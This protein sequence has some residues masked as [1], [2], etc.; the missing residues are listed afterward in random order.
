[1]SQPDHSK[2]RAKAA[3]FLGCG[4]LVAVAAV[5]LAGYIQW[6]N[7]LPPPEP[8]TVKLPNPN[9][10]DAIQRAA[11]GLTGEM[12]K[13]PESAAREDLER[14]VRADAAALKEVRRALR[15]PFR[16]PAVRPDTAGDALMLTPFR[17]AARAFT[18]EAELRRRE[19]RP[20][21]C[22]QGA[23]DT[24][25]LG[26][27]LRHGGQLIHGLVGASIEMMAQHAADACMDQLSAR[28]ARQAGGRLDGILKAT[29]PY[30]GMLDAER[31][32][33][34]A[35]LRGM[36]AS[37]HQSLYPR[38]L[39][40][41]AVDGYYR[42][43]IAESKKPRSSRSKPPVPRET[44]SRLTCEGVPR[45]AERFEEWDARN[46]LLRLQLA[47]REHEARTGRAPQ[48]LQELVPATLPSLPVEPFSGKPFVFARQEAG[49]I[50]YSVGPDGVDDGGVRNLDLDAAGRTVGDIIVRSR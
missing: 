22:I 16:V 29:A 15:L 31:R 32:S 37:G 13:R 45:A 18:A 43:Y 33:A 25:E 40:Y 6:A 35:D 11:T 46:A 7:A 17:T 41:R 36:A 50:V 49:W 19:G 28:D 30:S 2:R 4:G 8:D 44:L 1:V 21:L 24:I 9:G 39:A 27:R 34:L 5:L 48:T 20:D 47:L 23:L 3:L 26:N 10:F 14:S 42:A 38:S 12:F